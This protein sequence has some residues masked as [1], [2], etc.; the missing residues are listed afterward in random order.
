V[1]W[2]ELQDPKI[3]RHCYWAYPEDY[4]HIAMREV[5]RVD[6]LWSGEEVSIYEQL[7]EKT[8]ELQKDLP[9]YI[10]EIIERHLLS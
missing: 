8:H 7:K 5:R 1:N 10:K 3:C 6:I 2:L 9:A 4:E